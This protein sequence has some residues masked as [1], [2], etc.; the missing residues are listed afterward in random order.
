MGENF[1]RKFLR[2]S[3][4]KFFRRLGSGEN[5]LAPAPKEGLAGLK[6][7]QNERFGPGPKGARKGVQNGAKNGAKM[8][9]KRAPKVSLF[10][11]PK[12]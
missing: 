7:M 2:K 8:E 12:Q 5:L 11:A 1:H 4:R 3:F 9:P 6:T 10:G